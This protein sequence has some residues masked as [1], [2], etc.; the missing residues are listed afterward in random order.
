MILVGYIT[1][2]AFILITLYY[3]MQVGPMAEKFGRAL[4]VWAIENV[5][6]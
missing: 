4:R 5:I 3:S 1:K 2:N 6:T